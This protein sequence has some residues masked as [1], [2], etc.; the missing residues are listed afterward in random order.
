MHEQI[1]FLN[2]ILPS[3]YTTGTKSPP[4][5]S[6]ESNTELK[7]KVK[8]FSSISQSIDDFIVH[9]SEADE[10]HQETH[11]NAYLYPVR[12]KENNLTERIQPEKMR[13]LLR[14]LLG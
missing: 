11:S 5:E 2:S 7:P 6:E 8:S 10:E 3:P 4:P 13:L 9:S 14:I 1:L 12:S